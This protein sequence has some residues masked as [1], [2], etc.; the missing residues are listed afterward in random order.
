MVRMDGIFNSHAPRSPYTRVYVYS[1]GKAILR[2]YS[3][4]RGRLNRCVS[5][6]DFSGSRYGFY[7][8]LITRTDR[9][10]GVR[11]T[12]LGQIDRSID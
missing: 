8:P 5:V 3:I 4:I 9:E 7:S 2:N 1:S 11:V 10:S 12:L 6:S